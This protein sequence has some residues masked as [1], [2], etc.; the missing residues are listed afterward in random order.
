MGTV[1]KAHDP[2]L[3]RFVALKLIQEGS[4]GDFRRLQREAQI[5]ASLRHPGIVAVYETGIADDR[6]YI[7]MEYIEGVTAE[8]SH[9]TIRR[10]AEIVRDAAVAIHY[11]HGKGVIHRDIKPG[12]VLVERDGRV[13]VTDFGLA[14]DTETRWAQSASGAVMG[15]PAFMS[16]EQ[17]M[18]RAKYA[19]ARTDVWG[20]GA[21]L[22]YLLT[23]YAP[24][25]GGSIHEVTSR[26]LKEEPT[27][28]RKR[29]PRLPQDLETIVLRCL[30]KERRRRFASAQDLAED[31]TRFLNGEAIRARPA[32]AFYRMRKALGRRRAWVAMAGVTLA[33]VGIAGGAFVN[34][35]REKQTKRA[36]GGRALAM[37]ESLY[38]EG[39]WTE[40]KGW[41][42]QARGLGMTVRAE[43]YE[44]CVTEERR[45]HWLA[46]REQEL[47]RYV[48]RAE[49]FLRRA[50]QA[51]RGGVSGGREWRESV[52]EAIRIL[53][54][55]M[56]LDPTWPAGS[57]AR[58]RAKIEGNDLEGAIGEF[59]EALRHDPEFSIARYERGKAYLAKMMLEEIV[60]RDLDSRAE[61]RAEGFRKAA[62]E[63]LESGAVRG[64]RLEADELEVLE[65]FRISASEPAEVAMRQIERLLE[66][67]PT[68][69]RLW[70]LLGDLRW[71]RDE[72]AAA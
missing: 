46:R 43:H 27:A 7:A 71:R 11:A 18:G 35:V 33:A 32:S 9:C 72:L 28:P 30:E 24:F 68:E 4:P 70:R 5:A 20:L 54:E 17:A 10:A 1:W 69:T 52:T 25:E 62:Q 66:K 57:V 14:R 42:D 15:T 44:R 61:E 51:R 55:A 2:Q 56:E 38:A 48:H 19:D 39:K 59:T 8:A 26:I 65:C 49:T 60:H 67:R 45:V 23:G 21:T 40:A 3:N 41:Y 36:R 29:N 16:P 63:D 53:D 13:V 31:L 47:G 37:G 22:Y 64:M 50:E 6:G 58:G 12:N 34:A